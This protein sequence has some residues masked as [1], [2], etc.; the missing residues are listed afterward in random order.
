MASG[1]VDEKSEGDKADGVHDVVGLVIVIDKLLGEDALMVRPARE[2]S[3]VVRRVY[4]L[5]K[6]LYLAQ[7][8]FMIDYSCVV[9]G[10][11]ENEAL[12]ED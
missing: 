8:P 12:V 2:V 3:A 7:I 1:S 4:A 6:G 11:C 9:Q 5:S 10:S